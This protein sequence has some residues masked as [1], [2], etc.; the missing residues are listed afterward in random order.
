MSTQTVKTRVNTSSGTPVVEFK[1]NDT[2]VNDVTLNFSED[3]TAKFTLEDGG[4]YI[5]FGALQC[6]TSSTTG[7]AEDP[8]TDWCFKIINAGNTIVFNNSCDNQ[9]EIGIKLTLIPQG[10]IN[11]ADEIVSADPKIK[12]VP[13]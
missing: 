12:N 6:A 11:I 4:S 13:V 10:D 9:Q 1:V 5:F 7:D 8:D 3:G 2:W